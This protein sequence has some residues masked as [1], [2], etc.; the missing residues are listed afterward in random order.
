MSDCLLQDDLSLSD[1]VKKKEPK[2]IFAYA[3]SKGV[4]VKM[5]RNNLVIDRIRY[6]STEAL[7]HDLSIE[8]AKIVKVKDGLAFQGEHAPLSNLHRRDFKFE[9]RDHN[10]SVQALQFKHATVCKQVHVAQKIIETKKSYEIIRL[11]NKLDESEE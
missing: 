3:K 7:P 9:G 4:D 5:R 11:A 10:S 8:K 1:Q 6:S 2:A